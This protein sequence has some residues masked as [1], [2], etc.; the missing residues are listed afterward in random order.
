MNPTLDDIERATKRR[1][2]A[3]YASA[4]RA[5]GK[6]AKDLESFVPDAG[7]DGGVPRPLD[8]FERGVGEYRAVLE[9]ASRH[10]SGMAAAL[11]AGNTESATLEARQLEEATRQAKSVVKRIDSAC[12]PDF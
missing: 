5:Y 2:P 10:T 9:A 3:T 8:A 11:D 7:L 12:R 6:L 1:S 4:S